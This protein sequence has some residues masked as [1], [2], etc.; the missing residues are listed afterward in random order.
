MSLGVRDLQHPHNHQG[1]QNMNEPELNEVTK[2]TIEKAEQGADV[3]QVKDAD[4]LSVVL[5]IYDEQIRQLADR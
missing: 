4:E 5:E 3:H 2:E 1:L